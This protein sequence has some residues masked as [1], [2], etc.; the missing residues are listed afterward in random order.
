MSS[1]WAQRN[2]IN[3]VDR[4]TSNI[5]KVK[6]NERFYIKYTNCMEV[7]FD[8]LDYILDIDKDNISTQRPINPTWIP[9]HD[10]FLGNK[11]ADNL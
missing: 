11:E 1:N 2:R 10:I 9:G 8:V 6:L 3:V 7:Y 5:Y 4:S